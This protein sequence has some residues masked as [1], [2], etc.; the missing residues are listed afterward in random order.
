VALDLVLFTVPSRTGTYVLNDSRDFSK[1]KI[2]CLA[3]YSENYQQF[4][5]SEECIL[6]ILYT[7]H[8]L[9]VFLLLLLSLTAITSD[10]L[11]IRRVHSAYPVH[12]SQ[13]ICILTA[14]T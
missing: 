10:N 6:L 9:F 2:K 11:V 8:K 5:L 7:H 4:W 14:I 1:W 13:I 12:T 3:Y